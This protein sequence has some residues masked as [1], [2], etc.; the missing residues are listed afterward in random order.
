MRENS[1]SNDATRQWRQFAGVLQTVIT[2][3]KQR[4]LDIEMDEM[5]G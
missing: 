2:C 4:P 1:T 5:G 3:V